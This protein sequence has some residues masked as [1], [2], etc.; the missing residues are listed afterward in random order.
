MQLTASG[1]RSSLDQ[2]EKLLAEYSKAIE[3]YKGVVETLHEP[4]AR[5]MQATSNGL[6]DY[7]Q[8]VEN[9]FNKIVEVADKLV[10]K[11]A[12]LL[13]SQIEELGSQLEELGD[14][15]SKAVERSNGRAK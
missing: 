8:S 13:N 2:Q 15:I 9:N 11:A 7:N 1:L 5:I 10:P 12:N 14:V 3:Q 4:I 6:R